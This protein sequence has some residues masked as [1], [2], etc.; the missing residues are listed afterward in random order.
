MKFMERFFFFFAQSQ[1]VSG[2]MIFCYFKTLDFS[3]RSGVC[4]SEE[5]NKEDNGIDQGQ[6][7]IDVSIIHSYY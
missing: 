6:K 3:V 5:M 1:A 7:V 4:D 2:P